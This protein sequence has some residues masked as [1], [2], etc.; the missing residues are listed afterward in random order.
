MKKSANSIFDGVCGG[1]AEHFEIDPIWVRL[2]F[3]F[4]NLFWL[5][6]V[7]MLIM[8]DANEND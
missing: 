3:V 5:Y 4:G 6:V 8:D 1:I 2:I 7:L